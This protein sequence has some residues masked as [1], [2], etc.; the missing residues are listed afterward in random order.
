MNLYHYKTVH[1]LLNDI[2]CHVSL[3]DLKQTCSL[4]LYLDILPT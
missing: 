1:L 2:L 3:K 4:P